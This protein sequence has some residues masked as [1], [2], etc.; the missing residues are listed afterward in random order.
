[1]PAGFSGRARLVAV[2]VGKGVDM[3]L[4][5]RLSPDV[6]SIRSA[7]DKA[8]FRE[9]FKF[10]TDSISSSSRSAGRVRLRPLS[11]AAVRMEG[12]AG[13][14]AAAE[15]APDAAADDAPEA[16]P[17]AT[18]VTLRARCQTT[19]KDYILKYDKAGEGFQFAVAFPV[20]SGAY[21]ALSDEGAEGRYMVSTGQLAGSGACPH[22][23]NPLGFVHCGDCGRVF[24]GAWEAECTCPWC[25]D[26][27]VIESAF[28]FE[29]GRSLG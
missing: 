12:A 23:G 16:T 15:A 19:K 25:G 20:D 27:G 6:V 11:G 17:D 14:G 24:C 8:A 5:R 21:D 26:E 2:S 4:L 7:H 29:L 22:C 13:E 18:C 3:P 28:D 10:V 1:A 9:F